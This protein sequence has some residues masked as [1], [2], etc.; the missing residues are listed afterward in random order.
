MG[1]LNF[2]N[3]ASV[4]LTILDKERTEKMSTKAV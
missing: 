1:N 4:L 2:K 3:T